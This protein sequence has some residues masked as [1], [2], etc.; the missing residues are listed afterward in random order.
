MCPN[1]EN[2]SKT[3]LK[4]WSHSPHLQTK[5]NCN[6]SVNKCGILLTH[7]PGAGELESVFCCIGLTTITA[8]P[9]DVAATAG[10]NMA[11]GEGG[12][13]PKIFQYN[14]RNTTITVTI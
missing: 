1:I 5:G 14:L 2:G 10:V 6:S 9:A 13:S 3:F 12:R 8:A 7:V 4:R 11:P